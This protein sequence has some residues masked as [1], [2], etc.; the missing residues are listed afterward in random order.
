MRRKRDSENY[1]S[2]PGFELEKC[3]LRIELEY[4]KEDLEALR[5]R[6][7]VY[8]TLAWAGVSDEEIAR[9][10]RKA[11]ERDRVGAIEVLL[12]DP[13]ARSREEREFKEGKEAAARTPVEAWEN[14]KV[15]EE[16]MWEEPGPVERW[17]I[18][19][20]GCMTVDLKTVLDEDLGLDELEKRIVFVLERQE[21]R[22]WKGQRIWRNE[23]GRVAVVV[24]GLEKQ[25]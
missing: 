1:L 11:V 9:L 15:D 12:R 18:L 23:G 14:M 20:S 7:G 19:G 17:S 13:D 24:D 22:S 6:S 21:D 3:A 10:Y 4:W 2:N 5:L 25:S 8:A 16:K